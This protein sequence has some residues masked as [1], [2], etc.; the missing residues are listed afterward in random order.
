MK[1]LLIAS[2]ALAMVA[3]TAQAQ[4]S[5][6]VYGVLDIGVS[7]V[8]NA[9]TAH[10]D[11][12][13]TTA[14]ISNT[15]NGDGSLATSRL[16]FRGTED[17]GQGRKA[18]F[19][20]EYDL[21][22][23]GTGSTRANG[24]SASAT[25]TAAGQ[26]YAMLGA[27]YS[28]VGL[29]DAKLGQLR[30]GQQETSMHSVFTAGLAG[31]ANN[32]AGSIYSS[33]DTV[34]SIS[35]ITARARP[36]DVFVSRAITY[37]SPVMSGVRFEAQTANYNT[38]VGTTGTTGFANLRVALNAASLKY[39]A[40]KLN[41]AAA[42]QTTKVDSS[43]TNNDVNTRD[44]SAISA[45]YDFGVVRAFGVYTTDKLTQFNGVTRDTKA[46]E[47]GLQLPVG[48]T[49]F[50][51]SAFEGDRKGTGLNAP[52]SGATG[53]ENQNADLS[54]YQVGV[55]NSLSKRTAIYA[56]YGKQEIKGT[57]AANNK[58]KVES[59]GMSVGVRHSF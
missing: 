14:K 54:G 31:G 20:L 16:G 46:T 23:A 25:T 57:A 2:A 45:N 40:G 47:L 22:D 44:G 5:V 32:A 38:D 1:K 51:A 13:T 41:L 53:L 50:W 33:S 43:A 29:E 34:N 42:V 3:G 12:A 59:T 28:W 49:M 52:T 30:L 8:K 55:L 56:I 17:L 39:S 4:S 35:D 36:Y 26:T 7:E 48:K 27:R 18:N 10:A 37:I 9:T 11:G 15:G 58:A 21:T 24:A 6:T 19:Q